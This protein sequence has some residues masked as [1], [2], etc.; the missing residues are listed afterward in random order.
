MFN[1]QNKKNEIIVMQ[2]TVCQRPRIGFDKKI[3]LWIV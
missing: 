3:N 1:I 2:K